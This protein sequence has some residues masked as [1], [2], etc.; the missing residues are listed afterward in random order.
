MNHYKN[1]YP[2]RPR[3]DVIKI[4]SY[5]VSSSSYKTIHRLL[6][7]VYIFIVKPY[8]LPDDFLKLK[9]KNKYNKMIKINKKSY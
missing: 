5:H 1:I 7:P 4:T 3:R 2:N 8:I 6:K 9:I